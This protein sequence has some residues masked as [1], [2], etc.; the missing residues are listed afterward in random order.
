MLV[1]LWMMSR[2]DDFLGFTPAWAGSLILIIE[3][4]A[5]VSIATALTLAY[6]GGRPKGWEDGNHTDSKIAENGGAE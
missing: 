3:T 2:N 5:T 4:A 6:L 1:G